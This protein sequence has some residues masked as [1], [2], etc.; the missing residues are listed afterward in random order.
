MYLTWVKGGRGKKRSVE[1]SFRADKMP[2]GHY[3]FQGPFGGEGKT[4]RRTK[5][6]INTLKPGQKEVGVNTPLTIFTVLTGHSHPPDSVYKGASD[7]DKI[8][9]KRVNL[10]GYV[11]QN[12]IGFEA[13]DPAG[14]TYP[15]LSAQE[16]MACMMAME[17][18]V[19]L[20][21]E[22]F[23]EQERLSELEER[24]DFKDYNK[25]LRI[26]RKRVRWDK[27]NGYFDTPSN[28]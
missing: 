1:A 19:N 27:R 3:D 26:A 9:A 6:A 12:D 15:M 28:Q 2:N 21:K 8:E 4:F 18:I 20:E 14:N 22:A 10:F 13:Y 17:K 7:G 23:R 5:G 16:F 11:M 25:S 24:N